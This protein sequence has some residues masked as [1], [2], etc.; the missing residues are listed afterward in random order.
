MNLRPLAIYIH[1]PYCK[2]RCPYCDFFR[3][4]LP[5][6]FD[7]NAWI[8][9]CREDIAYFYDICGNFIKYKNNG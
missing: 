9:K 4:I 6:D 1:F 2:S 7:E 8:R 5:K 3:N